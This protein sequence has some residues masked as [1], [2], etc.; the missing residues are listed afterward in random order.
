MAM[1]GVAAE[2]SYTDI[3]AGGDKLLACWVIFITGNTV[4]DESGASVAAP[5][6]PLIEEP[7]DLAEL[8]RQL[9]SLFDNGSSDVETTHS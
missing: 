9:Q 2:K 7:F 8:L 3:S 6:T 5:G 4:G 1:N